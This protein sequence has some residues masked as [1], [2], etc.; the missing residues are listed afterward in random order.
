MDQAQISLKLYLNLEI[1]LQDKKYIVSVIIPWIK[2]HPLSIQLFMW[3]PKLKL[4]KL[5]WIKLK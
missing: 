2:Y 3:R 1:I 5:T 4:S